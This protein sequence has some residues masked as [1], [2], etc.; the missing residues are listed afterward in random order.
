MAFLVF[1]VIKEVVNTR[2]S[3]IASFGSSPIDLESMGESLGEFFGPLY[4]KLK[5][6]LQR[7]PSLLDKPSNAINILPNILGSRTNVNR[8]R[9]P[10]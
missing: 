5:N 1:C 8:A 2:G 7:L 4:D 9:E 10:F 6:K 3:G